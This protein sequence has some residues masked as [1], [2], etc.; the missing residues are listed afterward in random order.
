MEARLK[1]VDSAAERKSD[2]GKNA[3]KG[4]GR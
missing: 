1:F 3:P 4:G 2:D